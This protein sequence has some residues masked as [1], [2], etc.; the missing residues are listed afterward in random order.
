MATYF[1]FGKYTPESIKSISAERTQQ[2]L[3]AVRTLGGEVTAMHV[4][5]GPYDL[6]FCVNLP[7]NEQAVKASVSLSRLTGI[8][9]TTCPALAVEAFDKLVAAKP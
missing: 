1:M 5:L 6:V 3:E 4:L 7:G 2:A 9:F 8:G